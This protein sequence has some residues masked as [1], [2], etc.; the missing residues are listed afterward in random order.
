VVEV[1]VFASRELG[2]LAERY[3]IAAAPILFL[4][5][6]LWLDRGGPGPVLVRALAATAVAVAIVLLPLR[7]LVVPDALPHAFSLIPL[8][9]LREATSVGTMRLVVALAVVAACVLF[10][11]LPRSGLVVLPVLLFVALAAGSVS[12]SRE[13]ADQARTQQQRLLGPVRRWVDD[14]ADAPTAYVYDGSAYW[15][16]VWENLFWNRR[17]SWVYDLPATQVPGP[18]PQE[19][20]AVG[21][22][23]ELTPGSASS[24]AEYAVAPLQIALRGEKVAEARQVGTDR[25]GLGLWRLDRPLRLDTI[26]SGLFENGD[27]DREASLT[28]WDCRGAFLATLLVKQPQTVRVFLNERPIAS[29]TFAATDTWRLRVPAKSSGP[30]KL[31][32]VPSGLLGTTQFAFER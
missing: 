20:V 24:P 32:V 28:A 25:Q 8:W 30:C 15:T 27:V 19:H 18:L 17:I 9:H 23:G 22:D 26:T 10:A 16:A 11:L 1:G 21:A 29:R 4:G 6:A 31:R 14:A 13:V 7:K 3:L 2:L 12:A 5:F